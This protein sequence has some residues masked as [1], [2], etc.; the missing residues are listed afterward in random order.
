M[1]LNLTGALVSGYGLYDQLDRL[2]QMRDDAIEGT[3]NLAA[4]AKSDTQFKPYTVTSGFGSAGSDAN[5]NL[6]YNL[7]PQRQAQS[8]GLMNQSYNLFTSAAQPNAEREAE[9]YDRIRATQMPEEQRAG[10]AMDDRLLAQGRSG[11]RSD[12][13]GGTPE[14]LAYNK[15]VQEAQDNA[16]LMALQQSMA[17]RQGEAQMGG[18]LQ[19][20]AFLPHAQLQ[21]FMNQGLQNAQLGQAGQLAG[22]N[23]ASQLGTA[24]L[25]TALNADVARANLIGNTVSSIAGGLNSGTFDPVGDVVSGVGGFFGDLLGF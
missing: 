22:A 7:D 17:E 2:G 10:L 8:Q 5:G 18:M 6:T 13:Y 19:N 16:S 24:G 14:Q 25:Q 1:S 15:A 23:L 3:D 21:N 20:A 4:Q 11:I 9:I 12:A